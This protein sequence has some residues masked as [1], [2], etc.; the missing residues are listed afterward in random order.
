M[1]IILRSIGIA[2]ILCSAIFWIPG[3]AFAQQ[4]NGSISGTV[5]D[6]TGA[7]VPGANMTATQTATGLTLKTVTSGEGTYVFPSL[8]PSVYNIS[9]TTPGF[10]GYTENGLQVRADAA[11]TVNVSLK[12]GSTTQTISVNAQAAQVDTTTGTLEEVIGTTSV[13]NL[14]LNGRNAA[15]LTAE[16]AGVTVAP[17]A[18]ADRAIHVAFQRHPQVRLGQPAS[19]SRLDGVPHHHL[20]PAGHQN[21]LLGTSERQTF[22]K[23]RDNAHVAA[24]RSLV[25]LGKKSELA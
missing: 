9:V 11:L 17:S 22:Q 13:N 10:E 14:P 25:P 15:T 5:T 24:P 2:A 3:S 23:Q 18:Q 16:V 4:G 19:L 1:K 21:R 20:R 8:A 7:V 6:S 12:T